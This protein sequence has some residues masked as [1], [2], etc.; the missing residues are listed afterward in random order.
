LDASS[1]DSVGVLSDNGLGRL[2]GLGGLDGLRG[3]DGL[4]GVIEWVVM[5]WINWMDLVD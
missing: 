2:N 4:S 1:L 3:V 5:V